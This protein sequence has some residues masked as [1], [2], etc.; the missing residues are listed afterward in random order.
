[1]QSCFELAKAFGIGG[2]IF[3]TNENIHIA[4]DL[5]DCS[6]AGGSCYRF[7]ENIADGR[8]LNA[9]LLPRVY[10]SVDEAW[11]NPRTS[12]ILSIPHCYLEPG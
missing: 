3:G 4:V 12:T 7:R 6:G 1:M 8:K 2:Y 11:T 9:V 10:V 5:A